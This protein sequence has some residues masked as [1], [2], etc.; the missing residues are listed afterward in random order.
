MK[1]NILLLIL[2]T[3]LT[4]C[5]KEKPLNDKSVKNIVHKNP[6]NLFDPTPYAF[7]HS[8]SNVSEGHFI[9]ISGQSGG[10]GLKHALS[11]DFKSQVH[12]ALLNLKTVLGDNDLRPEDVLKITVLIVDHNE[13]KLKIWTEEMK[14]IWKNQKYPASTLIPVPRLA[15]DHMLVEVDATAFK[16]K[17]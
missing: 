6:K 3:L 4:N 15:L 12:S 1:K 11:N 2:T 10:E 14:K 9:F 17:K 7:S 8:T 13:D 16:S 5:T